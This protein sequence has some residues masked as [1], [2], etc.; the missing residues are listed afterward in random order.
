MQL[1]TLSTLSTLATLPLLTLAANL[2]SV[3]GPSASL[4]N[5]AQ[6]VPD[7]SNIATCQKKNPRL[8]QAI[9]DFCSKTDLTVPS[10]YGSNGVWVGNNIAWVWPSANCP[11]AWVPQT[12]CLSQFHEMCAQGDKN[13]FASRA[14]GVPG[15]EK[16]QG[17]YLGS[18]DD[19]AAEWRRRSGCNEWKGGCPG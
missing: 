3:F 9:H 8:A 16:C 12:Y 6:S 17:W 7:L 15:G 14:Y 18:L 13:G 19:H 5:D 10:D 1:L 4:L 2:P 11:P